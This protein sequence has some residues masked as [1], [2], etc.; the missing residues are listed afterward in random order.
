MA[1]CTTGQQPY[2]AALDGATYLVTGTT[3]AQTCDAYAAFVA[4]N[5]GYTITVQ[6]VNGNTCTIHE[7]SND[8]PPLTYEETV[9]TVCEA[10]PPEAPA[11]A[12]TCTSSAPCHMEL[13]ATQWQQ[14]YDYVGLF[15]AAALIFAFFSGYR[16][17]NIR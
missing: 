14:V 5:T 15:L 16:A 2:G 17:G 11:S 1:A 12:P 8:G 7:D 10:P 3:V 9:Y 4:A 13:T 6:A